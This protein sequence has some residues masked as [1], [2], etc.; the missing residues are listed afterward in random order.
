[1]TDLGQE[2]LGQSNG[3]DDVANALIAFRALPGTIEVL[4]D[5]KKGKL[6]AKAFVA[7]TLGSLISAL[8]LEGADETS[9]ISPEFVDS[10]KNLKELRPFRKDLAYS[11]GYYDLRMQRGVTE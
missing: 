1:M 4:S 7:F 10:V 9:V 8:E 11:T 5:I 2:V 3:S 6:D